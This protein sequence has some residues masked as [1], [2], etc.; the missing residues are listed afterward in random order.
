MTWTLWGTW[1]NTALFSSAFLN[2]S[3]SSIKKELNL[4]IKGDAKFLKGNYYVLEEDLD[5]LRKL[6]IDSIEGDGSYLK[7]LFSIC[8]RMTEDFSKLENKGNLKE[9]IPN[10]VELACL[11]D[12]IELT[13]MVVDSYFQK[14]VEGKGESFNE[15]ASSIKPSRKTPLMIYFEELKKVNEDNIEEFVKKFSWVGTH[16]LEGVGGLTKEKVIEE[17]KQ[18]TNEIEVS[19]EELKKKFPSIYWVASELMFQRSN[20]METQNKVGFS[21]WDSLIELGKKHNLNLNETTSLTWTELLRLIDQGILP[22]GVRSRGKNFGLIA[23][24]GGCNVI[25]GEELEEEMN[26]HKVVIDKNISSI[27]G[28]IA[29]PGK[30]IGTVKILGESKDTFK[31]KEGD[32][33]VA[34]ETT[35]D[36]VLAMRRASAFVTNQGG[37]TSHAAIISRELKKPCVIGTKIATKIFK[38]GDL[39]EV[40]NGTVTKIKIPSEEYCQSLFQKYTVPPNIKSHCESVRKLSL[41]LANKLQENNIGINLDL[42][43]KM[44]L[45]HDIFKIVGVNPNP[46]KEHPRIFTKEELNAR[47]ELM[48]TYPNLDENEILFEILKDTYPEFAKI[49]INGKDRNQEPTSWEQMVVDYADLRMQQD[50]IVSL[51]ERIDYGERFYKELGK[52]Y[53]DKERIRLTKI[54][55]KIMQTINMNPEDLQ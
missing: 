21:Y 46:T 19:S 43:S 40:D 11:T 15:F 30:V 37:I 12:V 16:A 47:Q 26:K 41:F 18:L 14:V 3:N 35:V 45:L 48:Q 28:V 55:N 53:F 13:A 7:K 29:H 31:V 44:A 17:L 24:D 32:I 33:I 49:F 51:Q 9:F 34:P 20:I 54:E 1:N 38:D 52:E 6:A 23:M 22:E 42:T 36:Y 2:L 5:I 50:T 39:I 4:S 10:M 27:K 25:V 8:D